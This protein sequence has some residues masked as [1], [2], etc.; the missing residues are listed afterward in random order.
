MPGSGDQVIYKFLGL[1]V[2]EESFVLNKKND[3][4]L[5]ICLKIETQISVPN[6]CA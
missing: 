5:H 3:N 1:P 6:M 2:E 4:L